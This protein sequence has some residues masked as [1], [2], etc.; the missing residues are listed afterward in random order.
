MVFGFRSGNRGKA[1]GGEIISNSAITKGGAGILSRKST[2]RCFT[3]KVKPRM[4]IVLKKAAWGNDD[5]EGAR[6]IPKFEYFS[7]LKPRN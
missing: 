4:K 5:Y 6:H 3:E 1:T 7:I 2:S